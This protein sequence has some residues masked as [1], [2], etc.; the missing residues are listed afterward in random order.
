[1]RLV[2]PRR[3]WRKGISE[4]AAIAA[5][6]RT[7]GSSVSAGETCGPTPSHI[8]IPMTDTATKFTALFRAKNATVRRAISCTAMPRL[9]SAQA[10]KA[11]PAAPL[12]GTS[13]PTAN[14]DMPSR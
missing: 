4:T 2:Q 14:W 12:A 5:T 6:A 11:S 10:P 9:R 7:A 1:M 8:A 13:E 3:A